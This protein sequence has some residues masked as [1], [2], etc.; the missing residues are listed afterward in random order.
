MPLVPC[1]LGVLCVRQRLRLRLP[2]LQ[3][4]R[5]LALLHPLLSQ[6]LLQLPLYVHPHLA[7]AQTR[8]E[9]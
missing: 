1:V 4:L 6:L 5:L 8:R 3:P 7:R 9:C 2:R